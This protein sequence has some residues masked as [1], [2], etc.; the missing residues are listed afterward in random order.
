MRRCRVQK[1]SRQY[2][3]LADPAHQVRLLVFPEGS[4]RK[5]RETNIDV[6]IDDGFRETVTFSPRRDTSKTVVYFVG[7]AISRDAKPQLDEISEMRWMEIG[8]AISYLTY[9]NDK[10][11][12]TKAKAFIS[13]M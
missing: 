9:E 8:Q 7:K 6:L 3:D 5:G 2:R 10:I 1:V 11:I 13:L 4:R 12:A